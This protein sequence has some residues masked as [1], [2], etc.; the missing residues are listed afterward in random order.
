MGWY[1]VALTEVERVVVT[2]ERDAHPD[3]HVRRKM[4]VLCSRSSTHSWPDS[5][6]Q[7]NFTCF[8][9][10]N[11]RIEI[12]GGTNWS[13]DVYE[14][15]AR[16]RKAASEIPSRFFRGNIHQMCRREKRTRQYWPGIQQFCLDRER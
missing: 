11:E 2:A 9:W 13:T 7:G 14:E 8:Q 16:A 12:M 4:L 15:A 10:K 3:A 5:G 1:R 6:V